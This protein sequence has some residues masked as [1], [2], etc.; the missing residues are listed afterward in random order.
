[1]EGKLS[2]EDDTQIFSG[3][4][5]FYLMVVDMKFGRF[6]WAYRKENYLK[7]VMVNVQSPLSVPVG[8]IR[9]ILSIIK[10][11]RNII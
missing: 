2:V 11:G 9:S 7:F 10:I 8:K 6:C 5:L 3:G 4:A 1:M